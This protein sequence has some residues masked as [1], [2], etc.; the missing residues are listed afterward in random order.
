MPRGTEVSARRFLPTLFSLG[1]TERHQSGLVDR[2]RYNQT[3][4]A[5]ISA[6]SRAR[7]RAN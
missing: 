3:V 2:R 5:L 1:Q 7:L 4:I 6:Q